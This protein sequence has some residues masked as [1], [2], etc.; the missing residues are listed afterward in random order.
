[1]GG[2]GQQTP[3][4]E[5][6][7]SQLALRA[8]P[9]PP[10]TKI[11][12][13]DDARVWAE[14]TVASQDNTILL[15]VKDDGERSEIDLGFHELH[16]TNPKVVADLTALYHI[17]EAGILHNV[18]ERFRLGTPEPYTF[19]GTALIAVNPLRDVPAPA[20]DAFIGQ[21]LDPATPHPYALAELAYQQLQ[22][23]PARRNQSIVINGESGAGK[24]ET[25]KIVLNYL[26]RRGGA[27]SSAGSSNSA[28][29]QALLDSSPVLEAFGN[30]KT[31]RNH[32]S[33]RF[34]KFI[35]LQFSA[36]AYALVGADIE[37]YLLEKSRVVYQDPEE[38]NFH[39][40][41]QMLRGLDS[42]R[43]GTLDLG[44]VGDYAYLAHGSTTVDGVDDAANFQLLL[45]TL[46]AVGMRGADQETIWGVLAGILQLGQIA[47]EGEDSPEGVV[48]KLGER[49][50][51]EAAAARLGFSSQQLEGMVT[52]R[53]MSTVGETY[54]IHLTMEDAAFARDAIAK[55][56]YKALFEWVLRTVNKSLGCGTQNLPFI[57]VLDIFGF[58]AFQRNEFSQLL[59]NYANE[60]LQ[61]TFNH[62]FVEAELRLFAEENIECDISVDALPNNAGCVSLIEGKPDGLL[63][64]LDVVA[65]LPKPDDLKFCDRVHSKHAKDFFFPKTHPKDKR[66]S[67]HVKHFAGTVKY[68][69]SNWVDINNDNL[70][71]AF[72]EHL[73]SSPVLSCLVTAPAEAASANRRQSHRIRKPTVAGIFLK[74]MES[75]NRTL[76]S[77]SC[78][79]VRCIKP[80]AA[81]SPGS[82]DNQYVVEQLRALGVLKT[83]EVLKVG[84][85]TRISYE[86][87]HETLNRLPEEATQLLAQE[88]EEVIVASLLY[89]FDVDPSIYR[90]GRTRIFFRAGQVGTVQ[91]I[92]TADVGEP[93]LREKLTD[94]IRSALGARHEAQEAEGRAAKTAEEIA[95]AYAALRD[96][97]EAKL[98]EAPFDASRGA[99]PL[100]PPDGIDR[101]SL[102][103]VVQDARAAHQSIALA[104]HS[105]E[106][107]E[108]ELLACEDAEQEAA[109]A[110]KTSALDGIE[111]VRRIWSLL[112]E[113]E[114]S[115]KQKMDEANATR[116]SEQMASA[117]EKISA[118]APAVKLVAKLAREAADGAARCQSEYAIA[119]SAEAL[120]VADGIRAAFE[121]VEGAMR[122]GE[123]AESR[124]VSLWH[125]AASDGQRCH[126]SAEEVR[127]LCRRV[128]E[129]AEEARSLAN[130]LRMERLAELEAEERRRA[131]EVAR[132]QEE[133]RLAREAE[134]R[135]RAEEAEAKRLADN[136][137]AVAKAA[138]EAAKAQTLRDE[139]REERLR[140]LDVSPASHLPEHSTTTVSS[141]EV[142]GVS[143]LKLA[144]PANPADPADPAETGETGETAQPGDGADGA[145]F[146]DVRKRSAEGAAGST[147]ELPPG[148]EITAREDGVAVYR[149]VLTGFLS[150]SVPTEA[151]TSLP[152]PGAPLFQ[153]DRREHHRLSV[154]VKDSLHITRKRGPLL[155]SLVMGSSL[156]YTPVFIELDDSTIFAYGRRADLGTKRRD[157]LDLSTSAFV[158]FTRVRFGFS[159][160]SGAEQWDLAAKDDAER[161]AWTQA[162]MEHVHALTVEDES[163]GIEAADAGPGETRAKAVEDVK[164]AL[165]DADALLQLSSVAKAQPMLDSPGGARSGKYLV[166]G[167]V[168]LVADEVLVGGV[169]YIKVADVDLW[170]RKTHPA[171]GQSMFERPRSAALSE[172]E[173]CCI[174]EK[175]LLRAEESAQHALAESASGTAQIERLLLENSY[176]HEQL[177]MSTRSSE[178]TRWQMLCC[179]SGDC[180]LS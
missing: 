60:S 77:T 50:A 83:C 178:A 171:T 151:A 159:I 14:A 164:Q 82:L 176:L 92:L 111:E 146:A 42:A 108:A 124:R 95:A 40:F 34:G 109:C 102:R 24:T 115:C 37:T 130:T 72:T 94:R 47:F 110:Q 22:L 168:V 156:R 19:M 127:A 48:A 101:E 35:K 66:E 20:M 46:S 96:A 106:E 114:V 150:T 51:L 80:N 79:F 105:V 55:F 121:G 64:T 3:P 2:P 147:A 62:H 140:T 165:L 173:W 175:A 11:W 18:A 17:H 56:T 85:P 5:A 38:R 28:L 131:Q 81:M 68:T 148:W 120:Q 154:E 125:D 136:A 174:M 157:A 27:E 69:V 21:P 112:Q 84:L 155:R 139:E 141:V 180:V 87:L 137:A 161:M 170:V 123:A 167:E 7:V 134:A 58:E 172:D 25:A 142:S 93:A 12:V 9:L 74:S 145:F 54:V 90:L 98:H 97:V 128:C 143:S 177:E 44:D 36:D 122:Q 158:Q 65:R 138:S 73:S 89:A 100:P 179:G 49:A 31:S 26:T 103:S 63:P 117:F 59:I 153:E 169:S 76:N 16:P 33:S 166:P 129:A 71:D 43:K 57:G 1:M 8:P 32:N 118:E 70:P 86:E 13:E 126:A 104:E 52:Q 160:V 135:R 163:L 61:H 162:V 78:S 41:F 75:L 4:G 152:S 39:V 6:S 23:A 53:V 99:S 149:N 116:G 67:F 132:K 30:A 107:M 91:G 29:T 133:E 10:G 45:Q 144:N 113:A 119:K 88:P 15:V